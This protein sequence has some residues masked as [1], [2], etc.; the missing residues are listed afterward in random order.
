[1]SDKTEELH[2]TAARLS[3]TN[4][5][6]IAKL[7]HWAADYIA[8][9]EAECRSYEARDSSKRIAEEQETSRLLR[10]T[11]IIYEQRIAELESEKKSLAEWKALLL[12]QPVEDTIK[13]LR[14][15]ATKMVEALDKLARLGN[16]PCLG[17]SIGNDIAINVLHE[18]DYLPTPLQEPG[19]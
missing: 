10:A 6:D 18:L 16:E 8:L 2:R 7:L 13:S 4:D 14:E 17:N 1:M 5:D 19:E 3:I 15:Q 11:N 9:L 12:A